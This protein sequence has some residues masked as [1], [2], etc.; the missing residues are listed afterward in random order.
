MVRYGQVW[1]GGYGGYLIMVERRE[2]L[3]WTEGQRQT[4]L[5]HSNQT[6]GTD[7]LCTV[8]TVGSSSK[9]LLSFLFVT[10]GVCGASIF[11][12]PAQE[13]IGE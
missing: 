12:P 2:G 8:P 4:L 9:S 6:G 13:W 3:R 1:Y 10:I 5:A 11:A 7:Q